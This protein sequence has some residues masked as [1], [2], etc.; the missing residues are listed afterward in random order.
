[1]V[2]SHGRRERRR[3]RVLLALCCLT[4]LSLTSHAQTRDTIWVDTGDRIVGEVKSLSRGLLSYK[5]QATGTISVRWE[6]A[7]AVRSPSRYRV[8]RS[9][10]YFVFGELRPDTASRVLLVTID[11]VSIRIPFSEVVTLQLIEDDFWDRFDAYLSTGLDYTKASGV[12][13]LNLGMN[14]K[15]KRFRDL[16]TLDAQFNTTLSEEKEPSQRHEVKFENNFYLGSLWFLNTG[17][18]YQKNTELGLISRFGAEFSG[19]RYVVQSN[20]QIFFGTLGLNG[21][22]ERGVDSGAST[23]TYNIEGVVGLSYSLFEYDQPEVSLDTYANVYRSLIGPGRTRV[24]FSLV[25][26][27]EIVKD[28]FLKNN[29]YTNFDSRPSSPDAA[30]TDY[31]IVFSLEVKV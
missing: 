1:M 7:T 28:L 4:A 15:Q 16:R 11:T 21:T 2:T 19:G 26:R 17:L 6:H 3:G 14:I 8:E 29:F 22:Q 25:L 9:D 24:D 31:G 30:Q 27:W 5:T 18:S 23:I 10:G 12:A 13:K 20:K